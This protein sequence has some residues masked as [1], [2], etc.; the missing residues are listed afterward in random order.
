MEIRMSDKSDTPKYDDTPAF[1]PQHVEYLAARGI[2][3]ELAIRAGVESLDV[4]TDLVSK[5]LKRRF[6]NLAV[7]PSSGFLTPYLVQPLD[8]IARAR[9]RWD[10]DR[11]YKGTPGADEVAVEIPRY[12]AQE[13]VPVI[14]YYPPGVLVEG[15]ADNA[16]IDL[17]IVEAPMK[18]LSM[19]A[20]GF[21]AI[22]MGGVEAGGHDAQRW[23]TN[24]HLE[25]NKELDRILWKGRRVYVIYDAGIQN[26]PRVAVG[27]AK[28]AHVLHERGAAVRFVILP[29]LHTQER[30]LDDLIRYDIDDQGPDD[31]LAKEGQDALQRLIDDAVAADPIERVKAIMTSGAVEAIKHDQV[32]AL[33]NDLTFVSTLQVEGRIAIDRVAAVIKPTGIK[34]RAINDQV[35]KLL[36]RLESNAT[37]TDN[38]TDLPYSVDQGRLAMQTFVQ[39]VPT[40][41]YL[42]DFTAEVVQDVTTDDGLERDL[43]KK[44]TGKLPDGTALRE[45]EV[46]ASE[47]EKLAWT[48]AW[49]TKAI[50]RAGRDTRDHARAAIQHLSKPTQA[51]VFTH[52]GWRQLD[53]KLVYL[54]SG[55][56][57]G[58]DDIRV[59][60]KITDARGQLGFPN[61]AENIKDAVQASL[62]II[63]S[64]PPE[65]TMPLMAAPYT[66]ILSEVLGVDFGI[67]MV[68]VTGTFKSTIAALL[69]C[70]FGEFTHSSL[71][72]T[73]YST[74]NF[75]EA[76]LFRFKDALLVI[77][78]Y[79]PG[80]STRDHQ[81][82][83][84]K[85]LRLIQCIGDRAARGRLDRNSNERPSRHPRGL[86]LV[87]GED[88]PPTN[89]STLG[90]LIV[91]DVKKGSLDLGKLAAVQD[92]AKLLPHAMR[93]FIEWLAPRLQPDADTIRQLRRD[94]A[95]NYRAQLAG[96]HVHERTPNA[97][98]TLA[99]G[100]G[101]FLD[102]AE[103]VGAIDA[104]VHGH[105]TRRAEQAW[106]AIARKQ[107]ANV[108]GTKPT[109]RYLAGLRAMLM[110]GRVVL[111]RKDQQLDF[112]TLPTSKGIGW[113]DGDHVYLVPELAWESVET[114]NAREGWPYKKT[115]MHKQ[116][117]DL[118]IIERADGTEDGESRLTV[119]ET[120]GGGSRR[121]LKIAKRHFDDALSDPEA[122]KRA[123]AAEEAKREAEMYSNG[124]VVEEY[125]V[126]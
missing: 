97:L 16:A 123:A 96:A 107:R 53:D 26:N 54:H 1:L 91:V 72:A 17:H 65:I 13:G 103:Y 27:A 113:L 25:I 122:N 68:G 51:T 55:G 32:T 12:T 21:S 108:E 33:L 70:H 101:L 76:Q 77:D 57:I 105:L 36:R 46:P 117:A 6:K 30:G 38:A 50:I 9:I 11:Y 14:P 67:W 114:F 106:M 23:K 58:A 94:T 95:M 43:V 89:E 93:G 10:N 60:V 64:G 5:S 110:Q 121:V 28:L 99:T 19:V 37:Q 22:G 8:G 3:M 52:M 35:S 71:P 84:D 74:A 48:A 18:A 4:P 75:L 78:N 86:A 2:P 124:M 15:V 66:A 49:G 98:A 69:M 24:R 125:E 56:G 7:Y 73:W 31:F 62:A 41:R 59:N 29:L 126:N 102:F 112:V 87:T 80:Q 118:G 104:D 45:L 34:A 39:G 44:V 115:Q 20:H 42:A 47:F 63:D 79:V 92:K 116:L 88:L 82:L 85:A 111:A 61:R 100:F 81:Q 83:T 40:I 109:E 120:L 119:R 90:R